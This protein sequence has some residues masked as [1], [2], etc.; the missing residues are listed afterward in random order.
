[1]SSCPSPHETDTTARS[2]PKPIGRAVGGKGKP[3]LTGVSPK[4]VSESFQLKYE[5][6][7]AIYGSSL[8]SGS[9][10]TLTSASGLSARRSTT[11]RPSARQ[12]FVNTKYTT[13]IFTSL[14]N[15]WGQFSIF[16]D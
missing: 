11:F 10:D 9:Q 6:E 15:V 12:S 2:K 8:C 1:M 14:S 4:F 3:T 7:S 16:I 5:I 13:S